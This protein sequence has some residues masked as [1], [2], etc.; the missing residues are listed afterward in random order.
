MILYVRDTASFA[1]ATGGT[2][3]KNIVLSKIVNLYAF[4]MSAR[5]G[6]NHNKP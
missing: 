3:Y 4:K 2:V 1:V 6:N 5:K